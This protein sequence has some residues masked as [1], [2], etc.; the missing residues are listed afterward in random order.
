MG[1]IIAVAE[2]LGDRFQS[3]NR[4]AT[5][6]SSRPTVR[7]LDAYIKACAVPPAERARE[8]KQ[9]LRVRRG[10]KRGRGEEKR[11]GEGEEEENFDCEVSL[12]YF[13]VY[14]FE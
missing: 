9:N 4:T 2:Q 8:R 12:F 5:A 11:E 13:V 7:R 14:F 6:A 1:G 10:K 3:L